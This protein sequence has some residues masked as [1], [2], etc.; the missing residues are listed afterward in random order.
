MRVSCDTHTRTPETTRHM[1]YEVEQWTWTKHIHSLFIYFRSLLRIK[2]CYYYYHWIFDLIQSPQSP[3]K[4]HATH[5]NLIFFS[6]LLVFPCHGM[7]NHFAT[8]SRR[9]FPKYWTQLRSQTCRFFNSFLHSRAIRFYSSTPTNDLA[10]NFEY[11]SGDGKKSCWNRNRYSVENLIK[12]FCEW[13][14]KLK[15]NNGIVYTTHDSCSSEKSATIF[16]IVP[17]VN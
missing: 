1:H 14:R 13:R 3:W 8:D 10:K 11:Q 6:F 7:K 15:I 9:R 5:W 16:R 17:I 4:P 12:M 2:L